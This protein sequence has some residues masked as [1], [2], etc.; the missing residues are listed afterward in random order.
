MAQS[1]PPIDPETMEFGSEA[2]L[3]RVMQTQLGADFL[4]MHSLPWV[5]PARDD[6]DAPAREG[7]RIS[8]SSIG[9]M[10]CLSSR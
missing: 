4:V 3:A 2:D 5:F 6:I 8:S 1:L 9:N 10:G 7:R